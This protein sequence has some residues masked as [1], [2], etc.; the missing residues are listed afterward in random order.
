MFKYTS[1]EA[2]RDEFSRTREKIGSKSLVKLL[3]D[4][5]STDDKLKV[6]KEYTHFFNQLKSISNIDS[7]INWQDESELEEAKEFFSHINIFPNMPQMQS[8][9]SSIRLGFSGEELSLQ[10][11]GY[12][13]LILLF[14][15]INATTSKQ[16]DI[17]FNLLTIEEPEA[18]LCINNI[19][20]IVSFMKI[21]IEKNPSTQLFYSTH[22]TEFIN[23]MNLKNVVVMHGGQAFS[24]KDELEDDDL[25]YLS[26]NPNLDLFKLFFSKKSILFE[27]ISEEMLI[28]SYIDSCRELNDIELLSFHKGF[29]KII[30]IWKKVNVGTNNKLGIIRD[31][32]NQS[33][34]KQGHDIFDDGVSVC[35]RTTSEYTLE[36]EIVNT[37]NNYDILKSKYGDLFGWK[38]LDKDQLQLAWRNAKASEMLTICKDII[39]G[40]L[41]EL[42][43]PSHIQ[44]VIDF[45]KK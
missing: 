10:G 30:D 19:R 2:E 40:E 27:G 21:L 14:V 17:A 33:K 26:K 39:N 5:L 13:N 41:S 44:E 37:G 20:L 24:F 28:R 3:K 22:N 15:L 42:Q 8:I 23:K 38:D 31:Y 34:A 18:H 7:I 16:Q 6:E 45:V 35:V 43:M 11:L 32:D 36:P 1:L 29:T 25:D 4:G 12:R 9:F